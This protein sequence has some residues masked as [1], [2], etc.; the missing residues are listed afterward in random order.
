MSDQTEPRDEGISSDET[1]ADMWTA[2]EVQ[3]FCE[4]P[5]NWEDCKSLR[6]AHNEIVAQLQTQLDETKSILQ[7]AALSNRCFH[8]NEVHDR[9]KRFL[10]QS[11]SSVQ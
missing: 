3:S 8:H 11:A 7:I 9:A 2:K 1:R 5:V 6:N 4:H 10:E